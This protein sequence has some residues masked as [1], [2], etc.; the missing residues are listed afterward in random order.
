[1]CFSLMWLV[2]I[3]IWIVVICAIIAIFR[4]VLPIVL[5]WL[6][7]AG[8]VVMQVLNILLIAFVIIVMLYFAYDLIT[9]AG[10]IGPMRR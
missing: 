7:V 5:S 6:G 4:L 8:G 3:L 10:A 9:C 2:Q 1:M